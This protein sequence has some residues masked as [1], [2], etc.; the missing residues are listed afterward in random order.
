[1]D[2]TK[3]SQPEQS[4]VTLNGTNNMSID[5]TEANCTQVPLDKQ[6]NTTTKA[7]KNAKTTPQDE[8]GSPTP[9]PGDHDAISANTDKTTD[10]SNKSKSR[11]NRELNE[12]EDTPIIHSRLRSESGK[13]YSSTVTVD[14]NITSANNLSTLQE[15]EDICTMDCCKKSDQII[16]MI[17]KLQSSIDDITT[18]FSTQ[19]SVQNNTLQ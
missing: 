18:K 17:T 8:E 10:R 16:S 15:E 5:Q 4:N 7:V 6:Q 1:M 3:I 19:E 12:L 11:K 13:V 14:P 2:T 9:N